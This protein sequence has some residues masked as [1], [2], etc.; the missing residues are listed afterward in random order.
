MAKGEEKEERKE[1]GQVSSAHDARQ[2]FANRLHGNQR[3]Q[4]QCDIS[5]LLAAAE[6]VMAN[7]GA[8]VASGRELS[9][10]NRSLRI[11]RNHALKGAMAAA[12]ALL[13]CR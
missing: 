5:P 9:C 6:L 8:C 10:L 11:T 4:V 13:G 2:S 12:E 1:K 3:L 7:K